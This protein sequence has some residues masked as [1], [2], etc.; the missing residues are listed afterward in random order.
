MKHIIYLLIG[1]T[2]TLT[3]CTGNPLCDA[4]KIAVKPAAQVVAEVADCEVP[5]ELEAWAV[6]KL[7]SWKVCSEVTA[8]SLIG[9]L[10]CPKIA[11]AIISGGVAQFPAKAKCKGGKLAEYG[12]ERFSLYASRKFNSQRRIEKRGRS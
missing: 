6:E 7:N 2:I 9:D 4:A 1:L 3:A 11:D 12:K 5:E 8:Q 10:V